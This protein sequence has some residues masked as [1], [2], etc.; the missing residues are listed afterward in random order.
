MQFLCRQLRQKIQFSFLRAWV[1]QKLEQTSLQHPK[2]GLFLMPLSQLML[3]NSWLINIYSKRFDL[4]VFEEN[5]I[6]IAWIYQKV[7][8]GHQKSLIKFALVG[9]EK[10][11]AL[12]TQEFSV[13][14]P[15]EKWLPLLSVVE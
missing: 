7:I 10:F 12:N 2:N 8:L 9:F 4:F 5:E 3:S 1:D 15:L 6:K 13:K 11:L 14:T